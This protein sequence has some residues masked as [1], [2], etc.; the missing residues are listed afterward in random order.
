MFR[1]E[2]IER[3][4]VVIGEEHTDYRW[5]TI[6]E[7]MALPLIPGEVECIELIYAKGN[8]V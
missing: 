7:A 3:H 2:L 4:A 8:V 5:L 6:E 1:A